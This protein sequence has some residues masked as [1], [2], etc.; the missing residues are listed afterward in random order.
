[1]HAVDNLSD[2]VD[3]ARDFL[4]PVE[5]RTWLKLAV[6]VL[7]LSGLSFSPPSV[8]GGETSTTPGTGPMPG[9]PFLETPAGEPVPTD[10]LIQV[11]IV[12]AVVGLLVW[13]A[14]ALIGALMEF[15]LIDALRTGTVVVRARMGE[16]V[17]KGLSLFGFKLVL[18]LIAAAVLVVPAYLLL[19][20][21]ESI[22]GTVER[23]TLADVGGLVALA[24]LVGL[25]YALVMRL[26]TEFV[27]PVMLLEDRG[28]RGG[29]RRFWATLR[30]HP[31]EYVVYVVLATIV[32]VVASIAITLLAAIALFVLAIPFVVLVFVAIL[33]GP[34]APV[35]LG[36]LAIAAIATVLLVMALFRMPVVVYIRYYALLVLGDTEPDL[37]LIPSRREAARAGTDWDDWG[38][39]GDRGDRPGGGR[40]DGPDD[41]WGSDDRAETDRDSSGSN[42]AGP[43]DDGAERSD[44]GRQSEPDEADDESS[45]WGYRDE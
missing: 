7:F 3:V 17:G 26:T 42:W 10:V 41:G 21:I 22:E 4:T 5:A 8:P 19:A 43:A 34:L 16:H 13:L 9:D 24:A 25:V 14:F 6:V 31:L 37:D 40:G 2:A 39:D 33:T 1:M 30:R 27:V 18:G 32:S 38:G 15:V 36:V 44:T 20:P 29:W 35:L 45:D 11:A 28:I 23:L 12:L